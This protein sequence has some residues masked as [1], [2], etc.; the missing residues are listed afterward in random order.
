MAA[1]VGPARP[2]GQQETVV[3]GGKAFPESRLLGE[4]MAV[5]IEANTDLRVKRRM[6]LGGTMIAFSALAV[7]EIDLYAEYTGTGLVDILKEPLGHERTS[8]AVYRQVKQLFEQRYDLVWLE[9]FGFDNAYALAVRPDL[10]ITKISQLAELRNRVRARFQPEFLQRPDGYAGLAQHYRF[11]LA[12]VKG[13]EHGLAYQALHE[14][15]I[16]VMDAYTTDGLLH[17][18][19][20]VLLEDDKHFFPP[21]DCAPLMRREILQRH[22]DLQTVLG[23]LAGRISS[24]RMVGMN[25]QLSVERRS[26]EWVAQNFLREE[27]LIPSTGPLANHGQMT[28][29]RLARLMGEHLVLTLVATGLAAL[30]GL[31]LGLLVAR[32][33]KFLA[34]PVLGAAGVIQTVPSLAMLAF[35]L[36]LLEVI[37]KP[38]AIAA[39]FLYALLPIVRNTYT[40]IS[41]VPAELI[42]AGTAM[43]MTRRQLMFT[44]ELPLATKTIM[45]GIRTA[46]VISVGTATLGA[47]IS[48][49]GLGEP[50]A[51]GLQNNDHRLILWGAIPAAILA[52][53]CDFGMGWLEAALGPRGLP[54]K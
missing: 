6:N 46:L 47:F 49:G 13:M 10:G 16:D 23:K 44:V 35:M 20:L 54:R 12:D 51:E 37:G 45:A 27:G 4:M 26:A 34:G 15:Q 25:Y 36:A 9:P 43:G 17:K 30:C 2:S 1:C 14:G 22:P 31:G 38:P 29:R 3:V 40:G 50:I 8:E 7:A 21:Y 5:M 19:Q 18:Y 11:T 41:S 52:L 33:P 32:H 53:A 42:E 24:R 28:V 48:A 39:L